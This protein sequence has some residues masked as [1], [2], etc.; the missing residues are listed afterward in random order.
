MGLGLASHWEWSRDSQRDRST[1]MRSDLQRDYSR[2]TPMGSL[3]D[4]SS[5]SL[6]DY[7]LGFS[8]AHLSGSSW[9]SSIRRA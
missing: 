4:F 5:G 7:S 6:W 9:D 8:W 3:W 1:A 2:E